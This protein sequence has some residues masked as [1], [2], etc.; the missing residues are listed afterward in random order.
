MRIR[1]R[2]MGFFAAQA[3]VAALASL[4]FAF[5]AIV[6]EGTR[7][8]REIGQFRSPGR[9]SP[10]ARARDTGLPDGERL[11]AAL[12]DADR[13]RADAAA[14]RMFRAQ[15]AIEAAI[16]IG[17]FSLAWALL[18]AFV[19]AIASR[20]FTRNLDALAE[21]ALRAGSDRSFRFP[22]LRDR[23]FAQ[24]AV[25]FNDMLELMAAQETRLAEA[26]RLEGWSEVASFLFHQLKTPLS[27]I[28]LAAHNVSLAVDR[29]REGRLDEATARE[30]ESASA[31]AATVECRRIRG[32]LDRFKDLAGLSLGPS[33]P[34][35]VEELVH[36]IGG[37]VMQDRATIDYAGKCPPIAG[38]R[39]MLEEAL[40][41]LVVN[42]MEACASPPARVSIR[43]QREGAWVDIDIS[44]GNGPVDPLLIAR[45]GRER[46]STKR[47]GTGLGL[48][49][50]RRVAALHGG[51][52]EAFAAPD[53]GFVARLHLPAIINTGEGV[54]T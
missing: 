6:T 36:A 30:L 34:V 17:T 8:D 12:E 21:G 22:P 38:D 42:A 25:T 48:L 24:V 53:G 46:F 16:R 51:S 29:A 4:V 41:N 39:R 37:R 44:D 49:F 50:V 32:L 5:G 13:L 45:A 47:E 54:S 15:S 20:A 7:A 28:E 2:F 18:A 35:Q 19:F 33:L 52:F 14:A 1:Q 43:G 10:A 11:A 9:D 31:L 27:S 40:L 26:S 3:I 23:E